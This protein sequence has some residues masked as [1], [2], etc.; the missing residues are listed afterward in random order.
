MTG[1]SHLPVKENAICKMVENQE[2]RAVG[3]YCLPG[4]AGVED[5]CSTSIQHHPWLGVQSLMC[6]FSVEGCCRY[7]HA[8]AFLSSLLPHGKTAVGWRDFVLSDS[9]PGVE[10]S[11]QEGTCIL[12]LKGGSY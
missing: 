2:L 10:L 6:A 3:A 4:E 1:K 7:V 12:L 5:K 9:L 8:L 11:A